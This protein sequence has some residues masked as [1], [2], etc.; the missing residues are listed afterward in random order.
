MNADVEK[1]KA[2][3]QATDRTLWKVR[4]DHLQNPTL[5]NW[6]ALVAVANRWQ[7]AAA[8]WSAAITASGNWKAERAEFVE[9]TTVRLPRG[10]AH[11][12]H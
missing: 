3:W 5:K 6:K 1:A 8:A 11:L 7:I 2:A 9:E 4:A 10:K 12:L